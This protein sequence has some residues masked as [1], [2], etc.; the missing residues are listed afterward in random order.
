MCV[1]VSDMFSFASVISLGYYLAIVVFLRGV[2]LVFSKFWWG[3]T[4]TNPFVRYKDGS[5][6][7]EAIVGACSTLT[8]TWV[9]IYTCTICRSSM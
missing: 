5:R 6:V 2:Y 3:E 8:E 9:Y 7:C 4:G 1:C